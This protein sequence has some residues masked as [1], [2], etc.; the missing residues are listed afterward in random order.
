MVE[1]CDV[2]LETLE[3]LKYFNTEFTSKI[4]ESFLNSL[5]E[6]AKKSKL[7]V[8]ID[9]N[10]KLINQNISEETKDIISLIYY[11]YFADDKEK[12]EIAKI[13][14]ENDEKFQEES[15]EIYDIEK[16]FKSRN[17][18]Y[19]KSE[20]PTVVKKNWIEKIIEKVKRYKTYMNL[21][22]GGVTV[23]GG[24]PLLQVKFLIEFCK[25]LKEEKINTKQP[26]QQPLPPRRV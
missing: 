7:E 5:K 11:N 12:N 20:L 10:K 2:A 8:K 17:K 6:L 4:S 14:K 1:I 23:T 22:G 9:A 13:W 15:N 16:V 18:N 26:H 25:R 3:V 21:S 24:E 19:I